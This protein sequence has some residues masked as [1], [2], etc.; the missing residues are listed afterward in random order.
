M[1]LVLVAHESETVR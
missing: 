1:G